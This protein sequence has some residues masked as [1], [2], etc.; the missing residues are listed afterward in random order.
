MVEN[1]ARV[2]I[3]RWGR[4]LA[5]R[6]PT[7]IASGLKLAEGDLVEMIPGAGETTIRRAEK[8]LTLDD[9]FAGKPAGEWRALYANVYDWGP[10]VGREVIED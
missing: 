1:V 9:L 10:D 8:Q 2:R 7:E 3:G 6:L 5:L 4:S